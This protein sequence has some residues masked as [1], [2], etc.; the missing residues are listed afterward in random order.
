MGRDKAW[1][2][3]GG[4]TMLDRVVGVLSGVVDEVVVVARRDQPLPP[5]PSCRPGVEVRFAHDEV[6]GRG[7]LGGLAPGLEAL[8]CE[9]AYASACDVPFLA[10]AFV[11]AVCE[12]LGDAAV[13]VPQAGG[14][15]HPLAAVYRRDAVR[16]H[17]E[18][19][20]REDRLRLVHL[21]ERVPHVVVP[22]RALRAVDPDLLSLENLNTPE[23]WEAARR[24]GL[25]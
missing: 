2:P 12:A 6:E 8:A 4:T 21:L 7:P 23:D 20:L 24:R 15:L 22:E 16:P 11:R 17:V 14:R 10:P 18:A 5:M 19:L 13:A 25:T 3:W 1:L 9:V